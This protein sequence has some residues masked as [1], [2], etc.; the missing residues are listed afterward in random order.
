M[1]AILSADD[2]NDFISPSVACI[3]PVEILNDN[4]KDND[5]NVNGKIRKNKKIDIGYENDQD[6]EIQIDGKGNALEINK[7]GES[8]KLDKAQISLSDCLACSGCIT[9]SE[10]VLMEQHSYKELQKLITDNLK[11]DEFDENKKIF[12]LSISYQARSS[13]SNAFNLNIEQTDKFLIYLFNNIFKFKKIIGLGLGKKLSFDK[14][15]NDII[16]SKFQSNDNTL[17]QKNPVLSSIC[18]GWVLYCEKTHPQLVKNLNTVKSPQQITGLLLKKLTYLEY[19]SNPDYS[20]IKD[21]NNQIYHVSLMPC[22]DKKLEAAKMESDENNNN[23][24]DVNCVITPKELIQLLKDENFNFEDL[25]DEIKSDNNNIFDIYNQIAPKN[26]LNPVNSWLNYEGNASGGY[27]LQYLI[28][29]KSY[30]EKVHSSD[31]SDLDL[32][33]KTIKGRNNDIYE[34]R[35]INKINNE[36]IGSSSVI[37]GFKNIQNIVRKLKLLDSKSKSSSTSSSTSSGVNNTLAARRRARIQ[38]KLEGGTNLSASSN[39]DEI[40]ADPSKTD[41]IEVMACPSGCI[42]GG[43][44]ISGP[45]GKIAK[46]WLNKVL[47]QYESIPMVSSYNLNEDESITELN[48]NN[49]LSDFI[50]TFNISESRFYRVNF[51]EPVEPPKDTTSIA[52]GSKW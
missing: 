43:G 45:E 39:S 7:K 19:T 30:Y 8:V 42:N 4:Q 23:E 35:L 36:I 32:D 21:Y 31:N 52:L 12:V 46:E 2:L 50:N 47:E 11:L 15:S 29:L 41:F 28:N 5:T 18:P 24:I 25:I 1:S 40:S 10:E 17:Q 27:S 34:I 16:Q 44:Q 9:S 51:R 38:S 33:F 37:N 20:N 3:K 14:I 48:L 22:F 13:I 49:W 26:W 6:M